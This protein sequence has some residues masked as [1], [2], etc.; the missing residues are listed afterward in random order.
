MVLTSLL[1][2]GL[3]QFSALSVA[4]NQE[5]DEI[6]QRHC[7]ACHGKKGDGDGPAAYLLYPKPRDFT[8][9]VF[10]FRSTPS[11]AP[12]TDDDLL[13]T[14]KR[15][16]SGTS[17]PSWNRL[18]EKELRDLVAYVKSFS[19][20]F[21]D[22]DAIEPPIA[23]LSPA[24]ATQKS[25]KAGKLIYKEQ[26][27]DKCHGPAGK[28]DGA[29][30]ATLTDD[31]DRPIRP[32]D[33]TRGP[34]LMKGGSTPEAIYRTF[35]TGLDGT[36]MPSFIDELEEDQR[37][38]LVHY[39]RSLSS[40]NVA[41]V[42]AQTPKLHAVTVPIDPSLKVNEAVWSRVP[43]VAVPLR[44]LWARDDWVDTVKVQVVV[45]PQMAT[46][47]F[48]WRDTQQNNGVAR[49]EDFRDG[50]ALQYVPQG[51]PDDYIG[52]PFIGMGDNED[53]VTIWHWKAD[54]QSDM[55]GGFRDVTQK[56]GDAMDR[57]TDA[58][59]RS[60]EVA[61]LAAGNPLSARVHQSPIEVLAA[62]G[63]GTLTS[64]SPANQIVAGSGVWQDGEWVVV[65]QQVLDSDSPL[66]RNTTLPFAIAAWDG[67]AGDRDGQKSV[68]Q[69]LELK[70]PLDIK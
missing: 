15:G 50:I 30:A 13:H 12:P 66:R 67:S 10:K 63:F 38:Q 24:P 49:T 37:W 23:I 47:R 58:A 69:W 56:H 46:F 42:L 7:T 6:Y 60:Y 5:V 41:P 26:E 32:Y 59:D 34:S 4:S 54:W 18:S 62:K 40:A 25:V 19:D 39:I 22:E 65:M 51:K 53:T 20:I 17:M 11:G 61:G 28:G 55:V 33:F 36:P 21:E 70:I 14:L 9:G 31:F 64:L 43:A 27:C 45:G 52:M 3:L 48:Q 29:S 44:P 1:S 16:I 8:S 2:L 68:S 57:M 35:M